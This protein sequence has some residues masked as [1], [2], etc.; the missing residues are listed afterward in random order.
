[1]FVG[2]IYSEISFILTVVHP[3]TGPEI[4]EKLAKNF[5]IDI[6]GIMSGMG[7]FKNLFEMNNRAPQ[8]AIQEIA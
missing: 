8:G 6:K 3:I 2:S 1:M 4:Q 7:L 5:D